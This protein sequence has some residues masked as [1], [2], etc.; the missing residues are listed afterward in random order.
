MWKKIRALWFLPVLFFCLAFDPP[1]GKLAGD[2][3]RFY[4]D[5]LADTELLSTATPSV[6]ILTASS[7]WKN[8][9]AI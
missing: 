8:S 7:T 6:P 5:K 4:M 2:Q 9:S 1:D 3:G